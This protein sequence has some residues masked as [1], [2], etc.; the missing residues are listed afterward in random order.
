MRV[1]DSGMPEEDRWESLLDPESILD[2]LG[3][4]SDLGDL[5]EL[6]CGYGTFTV[7][8]ARRISG[9]LHAFDIDAAMVARTLERSRAAGLTNVT[10]EARDVLWTGFGLAPGTLDGCLLFNILHHDDPVGMLRCAAEA[11]RP[12]GRVYVI[13]WRYDKATPRGPDLA[14]RPRPEDVVG[15]ARHVPLLDEDGPVLDLPPWHYG[16]VLRRAT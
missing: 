15:W 2:S 11:V 10:A 14:I 5:A 1:R 7:P 8:A 13:H 4:G 16:L 6:G 12:G 3:I 9:T